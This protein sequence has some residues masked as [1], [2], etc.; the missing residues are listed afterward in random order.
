MH[1]VCYR[2]DTH[3][4]SWLNGCS[5]PIRSFILAYILYTVP[6]SVSSIR[7]TRVE[8]QL[9]R[10][11]YQRTPK[12]NRMPERDHVITCVRAPAI[13][14]GWNELSF[15]PHYRLQT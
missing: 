2:R 13:S 10:Y 9:R 4:L 12:I 11:M 8:R 5:R 1:Q 14:E 7:G 6:R 15:K 3:V